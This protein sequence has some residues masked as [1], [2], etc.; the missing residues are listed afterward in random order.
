MTA[1]HIHRIPSNHK[2]DGTSPWQGFFHNTWA[3]AQDTTGNGGTKWQA[4]VIKWMIDSNHKNWINRCSARH[5]N[6]ETTISQSRK[7]TMAQLE[8]LYEIATEKLS[9][10]DFRQLFGHSIETQQLLPIHTLNEWI[11]P[12]YQA[13]RNQIARTATR[14]GLQDIRQFFQHNATQS[15]PASGTQDNG[16]QQPATNTTPS[17]PT[18]PEATRTQLQNTASVA[19]ADIAPLAINPQIR[20]Q[21]TQPQT[22]TQTRDCFGTNS[23]RIQTTLANWRQLPISEPGNPEHPPGHRSGSTPSSNRS[24][25]RIPDHA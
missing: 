6:T 15:N 7:E 20:N 5:S 4:S 25:S 1:S 21:E 13:V 8:K 22:T 19:T 9:I 10:F 14:Q 24:T 16:T 12:M 23:R 17:I 2:S 3:K 11:P 18:P